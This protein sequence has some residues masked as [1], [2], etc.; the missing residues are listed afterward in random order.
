MPTTFKGKKRGLVR[1]SLRLGIEAPTSGPTV[2]L[3]G[4]GQVTVEVR[5]TSAH[6]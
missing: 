4:K 1:L 5:P 6:V 3:S 2:A